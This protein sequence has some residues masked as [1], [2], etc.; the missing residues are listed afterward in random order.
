[1]R[2]VAPR[3]HYDARCIPWAVTCEAKSIVALDDPLP[4]VVEALRRIGAAVGL[5]PRG[6]ARVTP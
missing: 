4:M 3:R 1:M 2:R 6:R 5:R